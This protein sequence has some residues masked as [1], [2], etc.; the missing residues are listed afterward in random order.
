MLSHEIVNGQPYTYLDD[1]PL[2]ERRS[3]QVQLRRG[4]PVEARDLSRLDP[5]ALE[6]VRAEVAP[7]PRGPDE[8]HDLLLSTLV[9]RPQ[10]DWLEWFEQLW[11]PAGPWRCSW[12]TSRAR[13]ARGRRAGP[14]C[15]ARPSG[16]LGPRPSSRMRRF[17]PDYRLAPAR[18]ADGRRQ[19]DDAP[20]ADVA[21]ALAVRGHLQLTGPVTVSGLAARCA[22]PLE[23]GAG[24]PGPPGGGGLCHEGPLRPRN[25]ATA[26]QWCARHLLARIHGYTQNRLR[27]EVEPLS[28][29]DFMRFLLRWQHVAPGHAPAGPGRAAGRHRA[30][31]GFRARRRGLGGGRLPGSGRQLPAPLARRPLPVG[32]SQ[33]GPALVAGTR[34]GRPTPAGCLHPVPGHPGHLYPALRAALAHLGGARRGRRPKSLLHGAARDVLDALRANGA[35]FSSDLPGA[36][37][38]LPVEVQEGLWDLVARGIVTADGFAAVQGPVLPPGGLVAPAPARAPPAGSAA[39]PRRAPLYPPSPGEGRWALAGRRPPTPASST[40]AVDDLAEQMA[41]QLLARWGV[42]FW[43]LVSQEDLAV[44]WREILWS[45]R[46]F[47]A[48]G[49]VRGG[50]F[51][52]GFAGEQYALP[53]ALDVLRHVRRSERKDEL[54][55]LSAADPLNLSGV[56]LRGKRVPAV[57]TNSLVLRDGL[58]VEGQAPAAPSGAAEARPPRRESAL[59]PLFYGLVAG[60]GEGEQHGYVDGEDGE[61]DRQ[62]DESGTPGAVEH[63]DV[64]E[65]ARDDEVGHQR[66][67]TDQPEGGPGKLPQAGQLGHVDQHE[68][69]GGH[70]QPDGD[71]EGRLGRQ[72]GAHVNPARYYQGHGQHRDVGHGRQGSGRGRLRRACSRVPT[73]ALTTPPPGASLSTMWPPAWPR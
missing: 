62:N 24:R 16:G 15:G 31:A 33:L 23:P 20:D 8:L 5:A 54:V 64:L 43:D 27:R 29:Q 59:A 2:E 68:H 25:L 6:K 50:R 58:L 60:H 46:R 67:L 19:D 32:R 26:E 30:A 22:L 18:R 34:S 14:R 49:L 36:T 1:A 55:R 17:Q 21:A 11:P 56:V 10:A 40:M 70:E 47:E 52:N 53:E 39:Q 38:R 41:G 13:R 69:A 9:H 51:V 7:S 45:L 71:G 48:R 35:M 44:P 28:P 63:E 72:V 66:P 37:G 73:G 12:R 65:Q 57:R 3:R 42:V 61:T 4:L